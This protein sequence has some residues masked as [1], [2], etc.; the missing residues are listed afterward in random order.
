MQ[1]DKG[2]S[3][4]KKLVALFVMLISMVTIAGSTG[5]AK[6]VGG[7]FAIQ[8]TPSPII[9]TIKPGQKSTLELRI[10]NTGSSKEFYKMELRSFSVDADSGKVDLGTQEPKDVTGFVS[11]EQPK[12]S[13]E[14]GQWINQRVFVDTPVDAGFS[15]N[16]AI[17][18]LRDEVVVPQNGGAAIKGSVAVFALLNV[19]RP[20]AVRKLEIVE[21]SSTKKVY[22]YL[23]STLNLKIKNTGN[24][25]IAPK[26][27]IFISRHYSDNS[28]VDLLQVNASGGNIIPGS[29]RLL[30]V[31]WDDGFPA[32]ATVNGVTK[33]S[34]DM[35]KLSS[36]RIGKYS[37]K[38][39]VIYDDGDR[40]VPVEA[41]VSFWV[42]PWKLILGAI[43]IVALIATGAFSVAKKGSRVFKR[44]PKEEA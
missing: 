2:Y 33:L 41:V 31:D 19:D 6:A 9:A 20:D 42:I 26:G 34:W 21:F 29:T 5:H 28:H 10:N 8:V 25:I 17:M 32:R 4:V 44:K 23:P 36:L 35:S 16:F 43:V 18:V 14:P 13:L 24:T 39:I 30:P 7:G 27:N 38:A 22:E 11:F 3:V 37:A 12:F 15:Y 40:D 1:K